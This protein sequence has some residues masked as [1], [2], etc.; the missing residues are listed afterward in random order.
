MTEPG[1]HQSHL[2]GRASG[3]V[4]PRPALRGPRREQVYANH[5]L[6]EQGQA[7]PNQG[8]LFDVRTT[9]P[10]IPQEV[11]HRQRGIAPPLA[12]S[13]P[14]FMPGIQRTT[15]ERT[16]AAKV[17]AVNRLSEA[18]IR[19][20]ADRGTGAPVAEAMQDRA[21]TYAQG[22]AADWYQGVDQ[23]S[24]RNIHAPGMAHRD[25]A[26]VAMRHQTSHPMA[27]RAVALTSPRTAWDEGGARGTTDFSRPNI[28]SADNVL[29]AVKG[30][31]PDAPM[32]E[33]KRVGAEAPGNALNGMKAKAAEYTTKPTHA[34]IG[35]SDPASQKVPNFEQSLHLSHVDP[36]IVRGAAGSYT[37]DA[38]DTQ[39]IGGDE[40]MLK[41]DTGYAIAHMTGVRSALKHGELPPNFQASTWNVARGKEQPA[42]MGENRLFVS[43][44]S[45]AVVPNPSALPKEPPSFQESSRSMRRQSTA[46]KYDLEF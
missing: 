25:I 30:L 4:S 10:T 3:R 18:R 8:Q 27:T 13:Q 40:K 17:T 9:V 24:G 29:G 19:T 14:G 26:D 11:L 36:A 46:D 33:V 20:G 41:T 21:A 12:S 44:R 15:P 16:R 28:E 42:S 31:R 1:F 6:L 38:W 45:G 5:G 34:P 43:K 23:D 39:T 22:R 35:I 32:E 7:D 2:R 37:V